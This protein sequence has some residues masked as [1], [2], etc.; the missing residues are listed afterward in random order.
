MLWDLARQFQD[1]LKKNKVE[2]DAALISQYFV[3][4]RGVGGVHFVLC[5]QEGEWIIVDLQNDHHE[6]FQEID[7]K[8]A[9]DCNLLVLKRLEGYFEK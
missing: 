7:P 8:T 9:S 5:D 4:K 6:D 3:G 2:A 1:H